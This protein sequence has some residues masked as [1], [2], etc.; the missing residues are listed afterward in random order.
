MTIPAKPLKRKLVASL[1][2]A[3]LALTAAGQTVNESSAGAAAKRFAMALEGSN[4]S[5]LGELLPG[6]GKVRLKLRRLGPEDGSF[7]ARQVQTLLRDF[8]RQGS[9]ESVSVERLDQETGTY[10][11]AQLHARGIDREGRPMELRLH[12]SFQSEDNRWTLREIRETPP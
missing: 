5:L 10:A 2:A 6:Q 12:L 1:L 8:F 9:I 7:S 4:A 11:L 3:L